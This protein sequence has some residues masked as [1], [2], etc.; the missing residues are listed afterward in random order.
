MAVVTPGDIVILDEP[1]NDVDPLRR[2]LLWNHIRQL[3]DS[4]TAMILVTHNVLEAE[5]SMDRLAIIDKGRVQGAGTPASLKGNRANDLRL[6]LVLEPHSEVPEVPDFINPITVG[7]RLRAA[8]SNETMSLALEWARDMKELGF[9]EEFS[10]SPTSLEDVY[11]QM[12]GRPDALGE[13]E[14]TQGIAA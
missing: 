9:A 7:R 12:I 8:V 14:P 11:V 10:I 3:A 13:D 2:R 4:G 1:T 6:E 5:R